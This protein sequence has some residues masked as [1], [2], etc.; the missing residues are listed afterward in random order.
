MIIDLVEQFHIVSAVLGGVITAVSGVVG[1]R[2]AIK[3]LAADIASL[4]SENAAF[5]AKME[6]LEGRIEGR[7]GVVETRISAHDVTLGVLQEQMKSVAATVERIEHKIDARWNR[8]EG[9][10]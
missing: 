4:R 3:G 7:V 10:I 2:F 8:G 1:A 9:P 6:K 5:A